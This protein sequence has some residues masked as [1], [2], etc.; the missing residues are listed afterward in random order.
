MVQLDVASKLFL[1]DGAEWPVPH[2]V[3][4]QVRREVREEAGVAVGPVHILGSQP[5]P[6]GEAPPVCVPHLPGLCSFSGR[7]LNPPYHTA[8]LLV[9][10]IACRNEFPMHP[11]PS[12][13]QLTPPGVQGLW[14]LF[15]SW[16]WLS[17]CANSAQ[18]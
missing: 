3:V 7:L 16:W 12:S 1:T 2:N 8:S 17:Q 18:W 6:V 11:H 13:V 15:H 4:L 14:C 5:W 10:V 9:M